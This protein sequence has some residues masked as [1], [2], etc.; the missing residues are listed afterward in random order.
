MNMLPSQDWSSDLA[1]LTAS[2]QGKVR[3]LMSELKHEN[4]MSEEFRAQARSI[5]GNCRVSVA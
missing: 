2:Q 1:S 4:A 3:K 5:A